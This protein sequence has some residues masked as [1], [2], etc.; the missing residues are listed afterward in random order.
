MKL[1]ETTKWAVGAVAHKTGAALRLGTGITGDIAGAAIS[2][3]G[4]AVAIGGAI[5][6]VVGASTFTGGRVIMG[7]GEIVSKSSRNVCDKA[8]DDLVA[9]SQDAQ[10]HDQQHEPE[11]AFA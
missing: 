5:V 6:A 3:T 1:I 11:P 4:G 7:I 2:V 10:Q 8:Y 9:K